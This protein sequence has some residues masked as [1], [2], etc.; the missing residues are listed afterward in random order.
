[1]SRHGLALVAFALGIV[2]APIGWVLTTNTTTSAVAQEGGDEDLI[3]I[4]PGERQSKKPVD[5]LKQ[6]RVR[7]LVETEHGDE[8]VNP[9]AVYLNLAKQKA[10]LLTPDELAGETQ[11]LRQELLEL[12]ATLKLR[13]A[14]Q[15]LQ[16]LIDE[17]P[18]SG[19]ARRAKTLLELLNNPRSNSTFWAP[20]PSPESEDG[21]ETVQQRKRVHRV[22][23]DDFDHPGVNDPFTT[24]PDRHKAQPTKEPA[25]S[26]IPNRS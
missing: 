8:K 24:P 14:E 16:Q 19:A 25:R 4:Q 13:K 18:G 10:E 5:R 21:F 1:M 26:I 23:V 20:E 11:V 22:D 3:D 6:E 12:Q 7:D 15:Q 2:A 17:H 9:V